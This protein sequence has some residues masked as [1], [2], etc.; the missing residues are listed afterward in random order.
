MGSA[1]SRRIRL[2]RCNA[3]LVFAGLIVADRVVS[4]TS[5]ATGVEP[6]RADAFAGAKTGDEREVLVIKLCW[7][8][9]GKFQM[10]SPVDEPEQRPGEDQVEVTLTKGFWMAKFETTQGLWKRVVGTL[11]GEFTTELP[12][13]DDLPVGNVNFAETE[14]FC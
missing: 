11:P 2:D 8:P 3:L 1:V 12:E 13:G 10:G 9:P 6:L 7:C 5:S 4:V 14:V